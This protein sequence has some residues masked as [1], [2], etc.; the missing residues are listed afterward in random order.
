MT[1]FFVSVSVSFSENTKFWLAFIFNYQITNQDIQWGSICG[2]HQCNS[3][4]FSISM[5]NIS[6]SLFHTAAENIHFMV[7]SVQTKTALCCMASQHR[8]INWE[9]GEC[10]QQLL[11]LFWLF[12]THWHVPKALL[13]VHLFIYAFESTIPRAHCTNNMQRLEWAVLQEHISWED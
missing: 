4:S 1:G 2:I 7:L 12:V 3:D 9:S 10:L 6:L 13:P 11:L 5:Y 8:G